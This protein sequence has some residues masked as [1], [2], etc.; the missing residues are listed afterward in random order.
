[1]QVVAKLQGT[2]QKVS[3]FKSPYQPK[4]MVTKIRFKNFKLFKEWQELEIK[5]ITILIGKNN[6]GKTAVLKLLPMLESC[7]SGKFEEPINMSA[8]DIRIA[9]FP[10]ELIY[11]KANRGLEFEIYENEQRSLKIKLFAENQYF[12]IENWS[13]NDELSLFLEDDFYIDEEER[14]VSPSFRGF[15]LTSMTSESGDELKVP[16][17]QFTNKDIVT[18]YISGIREEALSNYPFEGKFYEK[19]GAKGEN[20]YQF[21]IEDSQTTDKK[22]FTKISDWIKEKF[23]GWEL[24]IEYDGYRREL[25]ALIFLKKG[26]LEINFSQTGTGISQVLPLIIRAYKPC[27][28][29]TLIIFEEPEGHLHPYAHAQIAQLLFDSLALDS[30]KRY[31]IETH[32]QNFILR[33]RRLVAEGKLSP[34]DLKIY[35][36]DYDEDLNFSRLQEI[37]VDS[38]GG[39]DHWP[40]GVFGESVLEARA[41]M[42]ANI[43]DLRNVG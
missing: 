32:S 3:T 1:L 33:M 6:T 28:K 29:E 39:V 10:K 30:N 11:G 18:D 36:V 14:S 37:K 20:L 34:D 21:L 38:G 23:E 4:K 27:E 42:N 12:K 16:S 5:P 8:G 13:W 7:L 25:P 40:D 41:I 31:L 19:S 26:N 15:K 17:D 22:S 35:Y 9:D 24:K 43:N 2:Y